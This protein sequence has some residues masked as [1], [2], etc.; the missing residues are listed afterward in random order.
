MRARMT[1][2]QFL[3][4]NSNSYFDF[5]LLKDSG[6]SMLL[7]SPTFAR[8]SI[9]HAATSAVRAWRP[10]RPLMKKVGNV[11]V[12]RLTAALNADMVAKPNTSRS[13]SP[14]ITSPYRLER[15]CCSRL[16]A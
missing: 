6:T 15:S 11:S 13:V 9:S 5:V 10:F 14:P 7:G 2:T 8:H 1:G 16:T 3:I 4:R 12:S